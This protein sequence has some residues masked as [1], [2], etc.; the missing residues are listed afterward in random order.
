MRNHNIQFCCKTAMMREAANE[1]IVLLGKS[2]LRIQ[3]TERSATCH[4]ATRG[5]AHNDCIVSRGRTWW[6]EKCRDSSAKLDQSVEFW[7]V[8]KPIVICRSDFCCEKA[9]MRLCCLF[10]QNLREIFY[11]FELDWSGAMCCCNISLVCVSAE[12][13]ELLLDAYEIIII[14]Y[15]NE[16]IKC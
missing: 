7:T 11:A 5:R 14:S 16:Q 2:H 12:L 3:Q 15:V 6:N 1:D 10:S 13:N 4:G 9:A 8:C